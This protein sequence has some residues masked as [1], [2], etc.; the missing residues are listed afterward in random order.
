MGKNRLSVLR[1]SIGESSNLVLMVYGIKLIHKVRTVVIV[2]SVLVSLSE[3]LIV[4]KGDLV[5]F[6][7]TL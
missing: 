6:S 5:H 7:S 3:D 2:L 1:S 4:K